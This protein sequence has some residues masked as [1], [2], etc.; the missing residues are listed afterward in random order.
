MC[1]NSDSDIPN[2]TNIKINSENREDTSK[3]TDMEI[4]LVNKSKSEY[5]SVSKNK[6]ILELKICPVDLMQIYNSDIT[7]KIGMVQKDVQVY[8][9]SNLAETIS[10]GQSE[11]KIRPGDQIKKDTSDSSVFHVFYYFICL[12]FV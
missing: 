3:L 1:D 5:I 9:D 6:P 8:S 11:M 10:S 4:N 12:Y 7:N 2:L